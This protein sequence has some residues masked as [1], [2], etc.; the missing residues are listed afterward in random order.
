MK[1]NWKVRLKNKM[2]WISI[3]PALFVFIGKVLILFGIEADFD[4]L[5]AQ[6]LDIVE[7]VFMLFAI[8]GIVTDMTTEGIKDSELAM[9]Y[10]EPKKD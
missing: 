1:I 7:A 2:F 5:V 3:I 10:E 6:L 9:T 4:A 8:L